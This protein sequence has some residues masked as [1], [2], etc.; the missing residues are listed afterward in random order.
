M[1]TMAA[2]LQVPPTPVGPGRIARVDV[3][4]SMAEAEPIWRAMDNGDFLATPYQRFELLDAWQT[5]VGAHEGA[6]PF[7]VVGYDEAGRPLL[8]LPL[9]TMRE[10]GSTIARFMGGKHAT[11]NMGLW[12]RDFAETATKADLDALCAALRGHNDGA[13]LLAFTQQPQQWR[14]IANPLALLA[15]QPSTNP[16]PLLTMTPGCKPEQR[17]SA[18]TRRRLRNKERKLQSVPGYRYVVAETDADINRLLDAFFIIKPQRMALSKLPDVFSDPATK[19]FVRAACLARLPDGQRAIVLHALECDDELI[20]IF[21]CVADGQ[22]FSTLFNTYTISDNARYS[23]GLILL[24]D[25]IDYY[26]ERGYTSVDFG[27]GSDE[28]KRTFCKDDE[29]VFDSFIPLT[30][31]GRLTAFGLS[32]LTHA[33][34][35]VKQNPALMH[36]AQLLR[37][38]VSR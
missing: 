2:A 5:H 24:R 3:V 31:R 20:S 6:T 33:K 22:R 1:M 13:D 21:S 38:A 7:I 18:S 16:C 10:N 17:I 36:M 29:P 23:P 8:L 35:L 15:G 26:A 4:R 19:A 14:G 27:I 32:S 11:F 28:Y 30:A 12:R 37:N 25:M 9:A 34:R